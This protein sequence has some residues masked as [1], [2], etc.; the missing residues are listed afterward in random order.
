VISFDVTNSGN[1]DPITITEFGLA[2]E[3][4]GNDNVR[5]LARKGSGNDPRDRSEEVSISGSGEGSLSSSNKEGFS[6]NGQ[7]IELDSKATIATSGTSNINFGY[8]YFESS[9]N[10]NDPIEVTYTVTD[11]PP[12]DARYFTVKLLFGDGT[13][14]EVY[15]KVT[16][17]NS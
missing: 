3:S 16:N 9:P 10:G 11:T 4:N 7:F 6:V 13:V 5:T 15:F 1:C 17:I 2:Y 12:A 14:K 8:L